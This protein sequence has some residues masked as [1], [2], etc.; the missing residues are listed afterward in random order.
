MNSSTKNKTVNGNSWPPRH[1]SQVKAEDLKRSIGDD[2]IDFAETLC[3]I[4]KDSVA[5]PVGDLMVFRDWQKQLTRNLFA[6]RA[7]G[8]LVHRQALIGLPRKNGKSAWL[9]TVALEHLVTGPQ[10]AEIYS[11]AADREQ[12]KIVFGVARR[13]VELEPS[14]AESLK[15]YRD[16]I[17]NPRTGSTYRALSAEAFTKEGLSPT[18]VAF[19][20]LHAQPNRELFDVMS[21]AMG[22]RLSPLL[23]AITTA[24]VKTDTSGKDSLCY[25]LYQYGLK[26]AAGEVVDPSFFFAWWEPQLVEA[27]HRLESTWREANPGFDDIVSGEDFVSVLNRTP[28]SEFR[29]K[30]CNQWASVSDTWLPVGSFES[31]ADETRIVE[32]GASVVLSFDGSFNGDCTVIVATTVEDVP[33]QFPVAVWEKPDGEA[34]D[35]QVP[36]IEVEDSIREACRKFQVEEI[37]CDPYRW[38]RTFQVLEDEGL[39]VV[40]FPQTASRMTP[41]TTRF[42]ESVM[43]GNMTHNGDPR[44]VRHVGNATLRVDSRGSRLA[45]E[46]KGSQRRID[47]AVASVMG[48]ERAVW[49]FSRGGS[50]PSV[51]DPWAEEEL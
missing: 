44:L 29:T 11:C 43:N 30:R 27:D 1:L 17:Y 47:L 41:A 46:S 37:A 20:E 45:K 7:D 25:G 14:L 19:D 5:G 34:A 26:V 48:L 36:V 32:D 35:W 21:L 2:V 24:G 3:K 12:A 18:L 10:G 23:V 9:S 15:V 8:Q 39:P 42:F 28:E 50:L 38:A 49:W 4:T 33:H 13:M 6:V 22:A 16:A 51:F 40:L 31:R